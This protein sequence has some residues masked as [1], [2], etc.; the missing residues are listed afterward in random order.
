MLLAH[1]GEIPLRDVCFLL[2]QDSVSGVGVAVKR[3]PHVSVVQD[4]PQLATLSDPRG[5]TFFWVLTW[6][7]FVGR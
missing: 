3:R 1:Y 4:G 2:H 5:V 6:C 7:G